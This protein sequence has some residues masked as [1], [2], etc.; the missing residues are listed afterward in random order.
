MQFMK[1]NADALQVPGQLIA[2]ALAI[3]AASF[4]VNEYGHE[5]RQE[6][7]ADIRQRKELVNEMLQE[8]L[9]LVDLH[10]ILRKASWDG[11][12]LLL[13]LLPL[14]QGRIPSVVCNSFFVHVAQRFSLQWTVWYGLCI[15][16]F[17]DLSDLPLTKVM[18]E[19][20]LS[21]VYNLCSL[22]PT[23]NSSQGEFIDAL[24]RARVFWYSHI[25]DGVTSGLRGGR[26]WLWVIL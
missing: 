5:D 3:W 15:V 8:I 4:G 26:I 20:S 12:R 6:L 19:A 14:T 25:L 10:G 21:Q 1:G 22:E 24:V 17:P 18:Y 23:V 7:P 16:A 2:M 11:V 13:L 9:Y